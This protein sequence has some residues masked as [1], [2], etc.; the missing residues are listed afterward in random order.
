MEPNIIVEI[1]TVDD[2]YTPVKAHRD[3][4]AY[5]VRAALNKTVYIAPGDRAL[6]PLGFKL[7]IPSGYEAEIVPRSGLANKNG[8]TVVNSPGTIDAGYRGEVMVI[9]LNT[10][11]N[12]AFVVKNEDRI[13]QMKIKKVEPSILQP[14]L[15]LSDT[16]RGDKGFGSTGTK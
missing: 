4:A 7:G 6:I 5:D 15:K 1:E 10:D 8:I 11:T 14:V 2:K 3:D 16:E 9:L 13:A 12:N